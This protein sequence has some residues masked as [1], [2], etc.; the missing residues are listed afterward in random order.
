MSSYVKSTQSTQSTQSTP[1]SSHSTGNVRPDERDHE[2]LGL[3][4]LRWLRY[5]GWH[6]TRYPSLWPIYQHRSGSW[7]DEL[8]CIER[9]ESEVMCMKAS[10]GY[11]YSGLSGRV[12]HTLSLRG[13]CFTVDTA[14]SATVPPSVY[15]ENCAAM[16]WFWHLNHCGWVAFGTNLQRFLNLQKGSKKAL[17]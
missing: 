10:W 3:W 16:A 15:R 8:R 4:Y 14:C 12:S 9:E 13:P 11:A 7:G 5:S 1:R 6:W 2:W 17:D